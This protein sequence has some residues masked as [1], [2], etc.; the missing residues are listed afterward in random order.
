ME[1]KPSMME[2][3][4]LVELNKEVGEADGYA[5]N[6]GQG[7]KLT[8]GADTIQPLLFINLCRFDLVRR[9]FA[10]IYVRIKNF[11]DITIRLQS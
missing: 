1:S 7:V 4:I 6:F 9:F 2:L 8:N 3:N 10:A 11:N 5:N